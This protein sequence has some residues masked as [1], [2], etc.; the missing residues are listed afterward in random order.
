[1][2][3]SRTIALWRGALLVVGLL[4]LGIGVGALLVE[5]KPT[6]YLG[7]A[8]WMG[9][10]LIVNDVVIAFTV[11]LASVSL[12]RLGAK[13]P[14]AVRAVIQGALVVGLLVTVL[15]IPELIHQSLGTANP[16]V[17]PLDYGR[18]LL[19]FHAVLVVVATGIIAVFV[20]RQRRP[21]SRTAADR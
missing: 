1:V 20:T 10:A 16:S 3:N 8:V 19:L 5:V 14:L 18:N 21:V 12:R 9:A 7:I 4:L 2:T 6:H 17:L 13:T 15:V 11:F